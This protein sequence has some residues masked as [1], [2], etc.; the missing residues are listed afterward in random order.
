MTNMVRAGCA[1]KLAAQLSDPRDLGSNV[2]FQSLIC[3]V[4][5]CYSGVEV[6][7]PSF[8]YVGCH[9]SGG[10]RQQRGGSTHLDSC[11]AGSRAL[12]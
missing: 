12:S 2:S 8:I 6:V 4:G 10:Y 5:T 9:G 1:A 3:R 7:T 11:S